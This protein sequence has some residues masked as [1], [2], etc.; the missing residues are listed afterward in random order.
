M[1]TFESI[2]TERLI[3]NKFT[4]EVYA[5]VLETYSEAEAMG[6]LGIKTLQDF[7]QEKKKRE[8]GSSGYNKSFVNFRIVDKNTQ[9]VLGWCG[10]HT[11]YLEHQRAEIG[12]AMSAEHLKAKGIMSEALKA[13]IHYGFTTMGLNRIEACIGPDNVPSLKLIAKFKFTKEGQLREHYHKN[14]RIEDSIMFS[15]L[16]REYIAGI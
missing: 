15:L 8:Q 6:I 5:T 1:M 3:L 9:D 13:I 2:E 4:K 14:G 7:T 10:Y 12:Y 16:K 11:W